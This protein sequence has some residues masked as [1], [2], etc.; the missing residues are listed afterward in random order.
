MKHTFVTLLILLLG[1]GAQAQTRVVKGLVKD[2]NGQPLPGVSIQITN[3]NKGY[4]TNTQGVYS[5]AFPQLATSLTISYIGYDLQVV[6]LPAG[7]RDTTVNF[8]LTPSQ[9]Q[10]KD[11]VVGYAMQEKAA[12]ASGYVQAQRRELRR[13]KREAPAPRPMNTED[14]SAIN[15]NIFHQV[16]NRPLS[17][18]S[19]DVDRASYSNVR[20]FLN[21][22]LMPPKDA[23][24]TEEMINYFDYQYAQPTDDAP[25]AIHTDMAVCPW[26]SANRLVRIGIQGKK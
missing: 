16:K 17:T 13:S 25:V 9:Q 10:L 23:I 20:R 3:T 7:K 4:T 12:V 6:R 21:Q 26:N 18:F 24:R 11:I 2:E 8:S 19:A 14:Y 15:E 5:G 1:I 22:G